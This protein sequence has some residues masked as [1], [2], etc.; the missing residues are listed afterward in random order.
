MEEC[1]ICCCQ[2]SLKDFVTCPTCKRRCC[3]SC[4]EQ[5]LLNGADLS[6]KCMF[7]E[8]GVEI[9]FEHVVA[10]SRRTFIDGDFKAH[11]LRILLKMEE[12]KMEDSLAATN[13]YLTAM[14]IVNC[15]PYLRVEPHVLQNAIVCVE[16]FGCGWETF[17][18]GLDGDDCEPT[19]KMKSRMRC[20][21]P[22]CYGFVYGS[23][24]DDW[25]CDLCSCIVCNTCR[26]AIGK[27][28]KV[29]SHVCDA[30]LVESIKVMYKDAR[31]CPRCIAP[32]SKVDG[33]DQMFC[34]QCHTTY[35]WITGQIIKG[36]V[37]NPH[38]FQWVF[39]MRNQNV[40]QRLV[41]RCD[42]TF[43]SFHQLA[44][45]FTADEVKASKA[46]RSKL[47]KL[48]DFSLPLPSRTHYYLAFE[49]FRL[50]IVKVRATSGNHADQF[51]LI[52][53]NRD[54]R[55]MLQAKEISRDEF[56]R[57][58]SERDYDSQRF[59]SYR[60]I[61][62]HVYE[63]ALIVFD[64]FH[65]FARERYKIATKSLKRQNFETFCFTT[66]FQLQSILQTAN[67]CLK[68]LDTVY[69]ADKR[70]ARFSRHPYTYRS[71]ATDTI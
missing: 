47:P 12:S 17:N 10:N 11:R 54:L 3:Q 20:P 26:E 71:D 58:V 65:T 31:P 40:I 8:C 52:T 28:L 30:D 59:A 1:E 44:R 64:N 61:Y 49:N 37:H 6:H 57:Q 13:A 7:V 27:G 48:E 53:D 16:K 63:L 9:P 19:E 33:C 15:Q 34:T 55:V 43:I 38:Y 29:E 36:N 56:C 41:E 67:E 45:C 14:K 60:N 50:G 32:I 4:F 70:F 18:W 46:L 42:A 51:A 25:A 68:H 2:A 5:F 23:D 35:S 39:G 62:F 22:N 24:A 21:V 69:G 66:Y